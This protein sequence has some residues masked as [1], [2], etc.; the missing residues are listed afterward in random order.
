MKKALITLLFFPLLSCFAASDNLKMDVSEKDT[1][2]S[3]RIMNKMGIV[4]SKIDY[5]KPDGFIGNVGRLAT[6]IA[7][8]ADKNIMIE[9]LHITTDRGILLNCN[10]QFDHDAKKLDVLSQCSIYDPKLTSEQEATIGAT[11][12]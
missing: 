5:S 7:Y 2:V 1:L 6:G 11:K 12:L 9:E 3:D 10:A 4:I 8:L